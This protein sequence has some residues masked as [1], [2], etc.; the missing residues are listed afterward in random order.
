L[1]DVTKKDP[2]LDFG[3]FDEPEDLKVYDESIKGMKLSI[4]GY[5]YRVKKE[6]GVEAKAKSNI[7][8]DQG[9]VEKVEMRDGHGI[10]EYSLT[11]AEGHSGSS[12]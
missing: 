7:Y 11:T 5:P 3:T 8:A 12:L 4:L 10:V 9:I 1:S 6:N 2:R